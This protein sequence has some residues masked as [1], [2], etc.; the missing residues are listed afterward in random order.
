[1]L[2]TEL[3]D[4]VRSITTTVIDAKEIEK[5]KANINLNHVKPFKG[6][7]KVHRIVHIHQP[8]HQAVVLHMKSMSC[9]KCFKEEPGSLDSKNNL[10][11]S[12]YVLGK[13]EYDVPSLQAGYSRKAC[14]RV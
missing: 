5:F 2:V 14:C 13:L 11:C 10:K 9:F 6:A 4:K 7:M 3:K 1:M 12:H 8:E